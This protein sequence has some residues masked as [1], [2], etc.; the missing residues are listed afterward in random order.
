MLNNFRPSSDKILTHGS[1]AMEIFL[2]V[3]EHA[4]VT[5]RRNSFMFRPE[6]SVFSSRRSAMSSNAVVRP[7][8]QAD[9]PNTHAFRFAERAEK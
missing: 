3:M 4:T 7:H 6:Q 8:R 5:R 1:A 2:A 9:R